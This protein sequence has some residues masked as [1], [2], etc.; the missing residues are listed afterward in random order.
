MLLQTYQPTT[1]EH[2]GDR[3][4]LEV[5][6]APPP[7]PMAQVLEEHIGRAIEEDEETLDE[8]SRRALDITSGRGFDVPRLQ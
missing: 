5:G 8:L 1:N 4:V 6:G 7:T 3:D 2:N